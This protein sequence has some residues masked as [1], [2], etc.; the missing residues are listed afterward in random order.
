MVVQGNTLLFKDLLSG[1]VHNALHESQ[2]LFGTN[3][4]NHDFGHDVIAA[5]LLHV[6][7]SLQ[8]GTGLH[9]SDFRIGN[10]QTAA[11]V[12]HH[13]VGLVESGDLLLHLIHGVAQVLGQ[14]FDFLGHVQMGHELVERRIQITNGHGTT[15]QSLVHGLEVTLLHGQNLCQCL[16]TL[17]LGISK[18]HFTDGSNTAG[19]EEHVLGTA[20]TDTFCT[21]G[22]S[23]LGVTRRIR[24]GANLQLTSLVSPAHEASEVAGDG[25]FHGGNQTIVHVAGGAVD[26]DAV[27]FVVHLAGNGHGV[28]GFIELQIAAAYNSCTAHTTSHN[29][30]VRSHAAECS[31]DGLR[32]VHAFNIFRSGFLT[33]Q[34]NL[35]LVLAVF[36]SSVS[37]EVN[38]T[39]ASA[40]RSRQTL[41]NHG[42]LLDG[43]SIEVGVQQ[44]VELLGLYLQHGFFFAQ[45]AFVH[46]V[47]SDLQSSLSGTLA[48]TGLQ[49]EELATL[50]GVLHVLHIT[51][52]IF[53]GLGDLH[54]LVIHFRHLLMQLRDGLRSTD[55]SHNVLALSVQQVLAIQLLFASGGVT[56]EG[57]AGAGS[58]AHV[59]ED[60]G[61]HIHGSAPVA[62][63]IV[64]AAIVNSTRI[65]PRTEHGLD[66]FHQLFLRILGEVNALFCLVDFLEANNNFLQ[67]ISSQVTVELYA[68]LF[69]ELVQ[70]VFELALLD[71]HHHVREHGNETAI[72]I[73]GEVLVI[74]QLCQTLYGHVVQTQVQDGIHHAR[75]G[76]TG[77]GTYGNQPGIVFIAKLL[78]DDFFGLGQCGI[79]LLLNISS[80]DLAVGVVTSA[81]FGGNGEALRHRQTDVGHFGQVSALAA[82]QLTH[83][84][85]A[86]REEVNILLLHGKL[87]LVHFSQDRILRLPM[88][89]CY[90]MWAVLS[91]IL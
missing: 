36:S 27:A 84:C 3:Q 39:C 90:R 28:V 89:F 81:G 11:T 4:R 7:S 30:S 63:D 52:V 21:K 40:G 76:S 48:V 14:L 19:F 34:D 47:N 22:N 10:S 23:L 16:F 2:F 37:G 33:N 32:E 38:C 6:D 77:T 78:A 67:V 13:G 1:F 87:L 46:Q 72:S 58:F 26:R 44:A 25:C 31:Q 59:A 71:F 66:G 18:D 79:N 55:A 5:F 42:C 43:I 8:H 91:H 65:V 86:F 68:P 57:N 75:H 88:R 17:F 9:F 73:V 41:C 35:F 85:V 24:I 49:H 64:H 83:V 56:G 62:G 54:E 70:N 82:Q 80:D 51:I 53:Q 69:L 74:G 12:T 29:S 60:H 20:Q 45:H 50:D 61:L 15:F